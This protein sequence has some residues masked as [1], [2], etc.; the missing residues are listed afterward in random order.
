MEAAAARLSD[1]TYTFHSTEYISGKVHEATFEVKYRPP[2]TAYMAWES[3]QEV[4]WNPDRSDKL[5]VDPGPFLPVIRLDPNGR[6][7][8]R[9]NRHTIHRLGFV[10]IASL[11]AADAQRMLADLD[12]LRPTVDDLGV[13]S[14][15]G[16]PAQC[17]RSV[18]NKEREPALYA[19]KVEICF[20]Q[21]TDLPVDLT[22]W[23]HED[24][25][26]RQ[27]ERYRYENL[28]VDVGLTDTDFDPATYGL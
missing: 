8:K 15:F 6:L 2:N 4:L 7:A 1:A 26:L 5:H 12:Q 24:G 21:A 18:M 3:G 25:E 9:G 20:D 11:F 14:V 19:H 27:I 17:Y 28:R 22:V 23:D 16:R 10:P 13:K